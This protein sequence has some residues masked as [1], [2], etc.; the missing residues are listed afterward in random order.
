MKVTTIL[1]LVL[2]ILAAPTA[3]WA[4]T[5]PLSEYNWQPAGS[6]AEKQS[7]VATGLGPWRFFNPLSF[8]ANSTIAGNLTLRGETPNQGNFRPRLCVL[9]DTQF[10]QLDLQNKAMEQ[11]SLEC[12]N[13][14]K[15]DSANEVFVI[16]FN[17]RLPEATSYHFLFIANTQQ[18]ASIM[19]YQKHAEQSRIQIAVPIV[20]SAAAAIA[21]VVH[22]AP[23]KKRKK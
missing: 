21:G 1:F 20:L 10:K 13:Q 7:V 14:Y 19:L 17:L 5:S 6:L 4:E 23:R 18:L 22:F 12:F 2:T 8:D 11:Q 9:T 3:Y 15:Y 16:D